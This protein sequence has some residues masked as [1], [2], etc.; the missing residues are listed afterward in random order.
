MFPEGPFRVNGV[1][2]EF[3]GS[4]R[5]HPPILTFPHKRGRDFLDQ[6]SGSPEAW[7]VYLGCLN[8]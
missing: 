7:L 8:R 5:I 6:S 1:S 4:G 3:M 2:A